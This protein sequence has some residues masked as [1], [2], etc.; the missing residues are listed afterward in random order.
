MPWRLTERISCPPSTYLG[1]RSPRRD[2]N[3]SRSR[4]SPGDDRVEGERGTWRSYKH[5]SDTSSLERA[6]VQQLHVVIIGRHRA[7]VLVGDDSGYLQHSQ[8]MEAGAMHTHRV[9]VVARLHPRALEAR[10]RLVWPAEQHRQPLTGIAGPF[11]LSAQ[12]VRPQRRI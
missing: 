1:R 6:P 8:H 10:Q 7:D 9:D 3:V 4:R 11:E 5:F 2:V 12:V